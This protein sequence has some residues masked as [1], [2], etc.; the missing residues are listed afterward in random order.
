MWGFSACF[1][2]GMQA[3]ETRYVPRALMSCIRSY[4]FIGSCSV[5]SRLIAEALLRQISIPPNASTV[6]ATAAST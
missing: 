3:R 6:F 2:C 4:D 1:R 5:P